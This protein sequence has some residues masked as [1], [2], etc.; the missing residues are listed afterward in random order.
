MVKE[1]S[2]DNLLAALVEEV[3]AK[4]IEV[5]KVVENKE[6]DIAFLLG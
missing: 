6:D 3:D 1:E 5:K 2:Q 4:N